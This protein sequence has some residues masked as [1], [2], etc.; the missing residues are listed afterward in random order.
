VVQV[1]LAAARPVEAEPAH[2]VEDRFDVLLVLLD[3]V[4]VV[5]AHVAAPAEVARQAEVQA[6]ALGVADVQVAVGLRREA[7]ADPGRVLRCVLVDVVDAG[8]AG[9]VAVLVGAAQPVFRDDV[10]DEVGWCCLDRLLVHCAYLPSRAILAFVA[11]VQ[12]GD[13]SFSPPARA[14]GS[15]VRM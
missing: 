12:C 2:R 14:V 13:V 9:P 4:G 3:R 6:D 11:A 15:R 8:P 7:G 10:A 1:V 5:E